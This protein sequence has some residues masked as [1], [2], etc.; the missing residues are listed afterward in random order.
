ML[1]KRDRLTLAR[2]IVC[3]QDQVFSCL[4]AAGIPMWSAQF[5]PELS[6]AAAAAAAAAVAA[7]VAAVAAVRRW[8]P[9]DTQNSRVIVRRNNPK[10]IQ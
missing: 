8:Q 7:A 1:S 9:A 5:T 2:D 3:F 10:L 4:A 6:E